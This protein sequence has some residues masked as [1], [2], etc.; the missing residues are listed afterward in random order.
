MTQEQNEPPQEPSRAKDKDA[1]IVVSGVVI[2]ILLGL[3]SWKV[4]EAKEVG[5]QGA[6]LLQEAAE[7]HEI[8]LQKIHSEGYEQG[9]VS[10]IWDTHLGRPLYQVIEAPVPGSNPERTEPTLWR[11]QEI[12]PAN[13]ERLE[14]LG[15]IAGP[16]EENG[17]N[18]PSENAT[19]N[20]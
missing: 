9:Y 3:L 13:R 10:A 19:A 2:A 14:R 11:R 15:L 16:A 4:N 18:P 7:R 5:L 17:P 1:L 12:D 20:P 6:E 8:Q